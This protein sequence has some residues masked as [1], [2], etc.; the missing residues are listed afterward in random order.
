MKSI[1]IEKAKKVKL[2]F[3]YKGKKPMKQVYTIDITKEVKIGGN[4]ENGYM[5]VFY[6]ENKP[7]NSCITYLDILRLLH[8]GSLI[9]DSHDIYLIN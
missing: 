7:S 1:C 6:P 4:S 9:T 5:L 8:S 3:T 2:L